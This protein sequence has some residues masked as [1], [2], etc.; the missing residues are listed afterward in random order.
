MRRISL[1]VALITLLL[2]TGAA[3]FAPK[4][5]PT[6]TPTPTPTPTPT[7]T[8]AS[9]T[10]TPTSTATTSGSC[11]GVPITP[12]SSIQTEINNAPE[13]TTFCFAA[14]TYTNASALAPKSGDVFNGGSRAAILDGANTRQYAFKSSTAS[15]VTIKGFVI[16][17]YNTPLQ[18]GAIHSFGTSGWTI[19]NNQITLNA[20]A[21]VATDTGAYVTNNLLDHNKQEGYAAHGENLIYDGN[22]IAYNN[23]TLSVDATWEAGGGKAWETNNAVFK[24]NFVHHN[25]GN[26][27][28]DDT[29]NIGILY[30]HNRVEANWGAGIYHEIGYNATIINN[31]VAGN[32]TSTSQGGGQDNGW[33]WDAGIQLRS[34][35]GLDASKPALVA[36]NIVTS[37]YNGVALVDSPATGCTGSGEGEFGPCQVKNVMVRDNVITMSEGATGAAQD[38]SGSS[39]FTTDNVHFENNQYKVSAATHPND[40]HAYGWLAWDDDWPTFAQWQ[41]YGHDDTGTFTVI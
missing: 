10:P 35:Q 31:T 17:R 34:S 32:G 11:S 24:N 27:L 4:P 5:R 39:L 22:E 8:T 26:G 41:G 15:N 12:S 33:M 18:Q 30:D 36:N 6:K 19:D 28:W 1:V 25:G 3:A 21:A 7:A 29:N 38:G 16:K 23:E 40:G 20:A 13:G 37:N 9:P 14:G 2:I